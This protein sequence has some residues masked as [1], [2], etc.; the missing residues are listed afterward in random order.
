MNYVYSYIN[1][2]AINIQNAFMYFILVILVL[3]TNNFY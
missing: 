1:D 2:I 3:N